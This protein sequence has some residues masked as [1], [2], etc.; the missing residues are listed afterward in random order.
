M[1]APPFSAQCEALQ[2]FMDTIKDKL[3]GVLIC[4]LKKTR[5]NLSVDDDMNELLTELAS[6]QRYAKGYFNH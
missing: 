6:L 3:S 1:I 5:I 4:L 2:I